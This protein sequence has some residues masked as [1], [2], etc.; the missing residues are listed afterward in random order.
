MRPPFI[1]SVS[2]GVAGVW[3]SLLT[4]DIKDVNARVKMSLVNI[5]ACVQAMCRVPRACMGGSTV[6]GCPLYERLTRR[7]V[8]RVKGFES[9]TAW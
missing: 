3:S 8:L 2:L 1:I 4:T 6:T 7:G 9:L 5:F